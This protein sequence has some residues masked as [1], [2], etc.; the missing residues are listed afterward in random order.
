[1][2]VR[3]RQKPEYNPA[4]PLGGTTLCR[5][6]EIGD[7]GSRGFTW[8]AGM[9]MFN[10]FVVRQGAE[11]RG[12]VD[13]CPHAGW[14]LALQNDGYLTRDGKAII[15]AVHGALFRAQD[16]RCLAGPGQVADLVPWP[17][18]LGDDGVIRVA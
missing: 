5:L 18:A 9:Q 1:V 12:Y 16:G 11:V 7:P 8:T 14:P 3:D 6:D 10:G 4:A 13:Y 2:S 15:C 17:V